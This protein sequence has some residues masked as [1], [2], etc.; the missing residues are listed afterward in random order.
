V[1]SRAY[2]SSGFGEQSRRLVYSKA[3]EL[4]EARI[5]LL[6]VDPFPPGPSDPN[7][8]HAAIWEQVEDD[9][10]ELPGDKRL[11]L[12]AYECGLTTRAYIEPFAV[13]D[14]LADMPLFLEP[15]GCVK[16]PL[17]AT[18]QAAFDLMPDRWRGVILA[19]S[20]EETP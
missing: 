7:G 17:E 2:D 15:D 6:M 11:T 14:L 13:G 19:K 8:I 9:S 5:H 10:F 3:S 1:S 12:V 20:K 4:L 18:Y 16:V